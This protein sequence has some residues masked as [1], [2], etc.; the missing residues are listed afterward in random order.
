MM[1]AHFA[2]IE[3]REGVRRST[4]DVRFYRWTC[5]CGK[6]GRWTRQRDAA[7]EGAFRHNFQ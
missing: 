7:G 2:T 5:T 6:T 3:H 4:W 1:D